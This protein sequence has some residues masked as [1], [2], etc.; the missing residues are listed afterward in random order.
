MF[1]DA[2]HLAHVSWPGIG[3]ETIPY[4]QVHTTYYSAVAVINFGEK[5]VYEYGYI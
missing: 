3:V 1:K 5:S 2:P 4:L